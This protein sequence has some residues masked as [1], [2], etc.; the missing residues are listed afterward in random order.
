MTNTRVGEKQPTRVAAEGSG[1]AADG[2]SNLNQVTSALWALP[3]A[4][5]LSRHVFD[6]RR[7]HVQPARS[8]NCVG[9]AP[10]CCDTKASD[11][12]G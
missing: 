10:C 3:C 2:L 4:E 11:L 5:H 12:A 9:I 6:A 1:D 8:S 7:A